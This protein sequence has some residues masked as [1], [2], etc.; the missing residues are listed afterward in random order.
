MKRWLT[1]IGLLLVLML[2]SACE[3]V[4]TV[5]DIPSPRVLQTWV[6]DWEGDLSDLREERLNQRLKELYEQTGIEMFVLTVARAYA[7]PEYGLLTADQLADKFFDE[8]Q[9]GAATGKGMLLVVS[10]VGDRATLKMSETLTPLLPPAIVEP[11][12]FSTLVPNMTSYGDNHPLYSLMPVV[13]TFISV[14]TGGESLASRL[15][16][17]DAPYFPTLAKTNDT[18][19]NHQPFSKI[20]I[21]VEAQHPHQV[22]REG[23]LDSSA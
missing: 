7:P 11:Y 6:V 18:L 20:H 4:E 10:L 1:A 15:G 5:Q 9:V 3:I 14:L 8:W 16:F 23:A 22:G 17:P 12:L 13:D 19:L 21:L 2:A